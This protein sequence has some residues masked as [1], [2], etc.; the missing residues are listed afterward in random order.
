MTT[1]TEK[2]AEVNASKAAKPVFDFLD[3][4]AQFATIREEVMAAVTRV[5]ESQHFILGPEVQ[6]LEEEIAAKLSARHAVGCASGTDALILSL[7]AAEIGPGD[8]VI[9]TPFSFIATAGSIAHVGAKP[10]FVDID[11][12]TFNIDPALIET[13]ITP[14]TRAI[15]PVHLFGLPADMNP[16]L[17]LA[18]ARN[19]LVIEDA[20]QAIGARYA[21]RSVGTIG[22]FGCFSFFPSKNLGA[23]GDG[24]LVTTDDPAVAERLRML[25]VHGSKKKYYH[26][27]LGTN[28]RLD[29]LQA[30]ILRVK[31]NHLDS[32]AEARRSHAD[33]YR[34]LFDAQGFA[35]L[36]THPAVPPAKFH[37]VYNQFTIRSPFRGE[38]KE[39]LREAGVPTEIYYPLCLHLQPA[40]AYLGHT[41]GDFPVA[42]TASKQVLSLPVFP[43]LTDAQQDFA[44]KAMSD[45][46]AARNV[47]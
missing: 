20:A 8:E 2:I 11:T 38:L 22:D 24:G 35:P 23:A 6:R 21:G 37:E 5:M 14:K 39:F 17:D 41:V 29:A 18:R 30:A 33:R 34:G 31:L 42:E 26:D 16:I 1:T 43:E 45:F 47:A 25:R 15:M 10:V 13:A 9:T 7:M 3:L 19:L 12:L 46:R 44:V 4:K 36:V 27:I 40:F 28:S 32:W